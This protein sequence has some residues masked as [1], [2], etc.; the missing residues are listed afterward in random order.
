MLDTSIGKSN[1]V[2]SFSIAITIT[3]LGSIESSLGVVI[4][5]S[6]GVSVRGRLIRVGRL[7]ISLYN[8]GMVGRGSMDYWGSMDNRGSMDNGGSMN[9]G[10]TVHKRSMNSMSNTMSS[11]RNDGSMSNSNRPVSTNGRLDLRKTLS[12]VYLRNRSM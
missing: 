11:N 4:G 7:S 1:R 3:S 2:R 8:G 9:E 12:I 6:V 5:N 10:S